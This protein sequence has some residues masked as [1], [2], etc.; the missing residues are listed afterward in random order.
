MA[1]LLQLAQCLAQHPFADVDDDVAVFDDGQELH[2]RHDAALRM[3]PAQQRF[4]ADDAA[5]PHIELGLVEQAQ[6]AG[7]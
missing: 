7:A 6:L 3:L 2:R 1:P 5:A 4:H